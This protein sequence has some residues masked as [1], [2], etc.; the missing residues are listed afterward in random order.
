MNF[1]FYLRSK[2]L[3]VLEIL[4]FISCYEPPVLNRSNCDVTDDY[5]FLF[6]NKF[7]DKHFAQHS[8]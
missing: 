5:S 3:F 8:S 2:A 7:L 6:N 1:G 4:T